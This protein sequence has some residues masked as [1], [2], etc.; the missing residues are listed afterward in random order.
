MK[1]IPNQ[2]VPKILKILDCGEEVV[3]FPCYPVLWELHFLKRVSEKELG[4][5]S[6][7][8]PIGYPWPWMNPGG[9]SDMA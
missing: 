2:G 5:R 9:D 8:M 1:E 6:A 7:K 3:V 4:A